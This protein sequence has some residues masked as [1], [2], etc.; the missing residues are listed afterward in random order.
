MGTRSSQL[1]SISSTSKVRFSSAAAV[2]LGTFLALQLSPS[3]LLAGPVNAPR[4]GSAAVVSPAASQKS[5]AVVLPANTTVP[6]VQPVPQAQPVVTMQS[7]GSLARTNLSVAPVD[8]GIARLG[9]SVFSTGTEDIL[10]KVLTPSG[11]P[12]PDESVTTVIGGQRVRLP[13]PN[14]SAFVNSIAIVSPGPARVLTSNRE[15]DRTINLG[16]LPPGEII[17]GI[18]TPEGNFF[19]TGDGSRNVDGLPHAI[20]K[21]FLSG[22]I[23]VWFEDQAG[24][25]MPASDRDCNDAVF[26]LSGGVANNNAVAEL[27]KIIKE[28]QGEKRREAIESLR[29]IDPRALSLADVRR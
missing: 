28:Q 27:T 23:Q 24:S 15:Y 6:Q 20:I 29:A 9:G 14:V 4:Q 26:Q 5:A 8:M 3:N 13:N 16:K 12:Y 11:L 17:F 7:G 25:R 18:R 2:S 22:I 19:K 21:T 10:L 1:S